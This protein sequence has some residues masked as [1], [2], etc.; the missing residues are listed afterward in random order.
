LLR[1]ELEI[2]ATGHL[3]SGDLE[4]LQ[5]D[6]QEYTDPEHNPMIP[7]TLVLKPGLIVHRIYK[8]Y[9]FW[10]RPSLVDLWHDLRIISSEI[11]PDWDLTRSRIARSVERRQLVIVSRLEQQCEDETGWAE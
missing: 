11:W 8:G 6:I 4:G 9:W 1:H 3:A 5:A 10:G 2:F 7:H